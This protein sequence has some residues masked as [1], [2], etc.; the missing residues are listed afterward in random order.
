[1]SYRRSFTKRISVYYS[2]SVSYPASERGGSVSY[3]GY[4]HEDVTVNINVD[5]DPFDSS[6]I[7]CNKDVNML[8]GSIVATEVAQVASIKENAQKVGDTII[9]GFFKTVQSEISQ[10]ICELNSRIEATLIHL[11]ELSKRCNGKL[12][13]MQSDYNQLS[14]RYSKIFEDLNK[15]LEN[16]IFEIDKPTFK[17]RRNCDLINDRAISNDLVGTVIVSNAENSNLDAKIEAS[18]MKNLACKAIN[19]SNRF[20][21]K[22]KQTETILKN[23][24]TDDNNCGTFYAPVCFI[25]TEEGKIIN[26]KIYTPDKLEAYNNDNLISKIENKNLDNSAQFELLQ[27]NFNNEVSELYKSSNQ[28]DERVKRYITQFFNNYSNNI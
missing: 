6:I 10:Q 2:G 24:I 20:L 8:T 12:L 21:L 25:Q 22:Q 3:S 23:S 19:E 28:H 15:E 27:T 16:R 26:K 4:A 5:T 1:M 11:H 13:Q 18:H 9:S 14:N 17:F 7:D